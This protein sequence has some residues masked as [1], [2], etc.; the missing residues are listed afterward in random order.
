MNNNDLLTLY[1]KYSANAFHL[2]EK[3]EKSILD[4][5]EKYCE[6]HRHLI[7]VYAIN[8]HGK[9]IVLKDYSQEGSHIPLD[10]IRDFCV[11]FHV[12]CESI[13]HKV[14]IADP[15]RDNAE[16]NESIYTILFEDI[17]REERI[18]IDEVLE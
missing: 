5:F 7:E 10:L 12:T 9:Y 4:F 1:M 11:S 13:T 14:G 3:L 2:E 8:D 6:E 17:R 15:L 18:L 16:I